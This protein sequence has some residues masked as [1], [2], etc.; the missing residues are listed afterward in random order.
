M[1]PLG[2]AQWWH[3]F[4]FLGLSFDDDDDGIPAAPTPASSGRNVHFKSPKNLATI[5]GFGRDRVV[6]VPVDGQRNFVGVLRESGSAGMVALE[7]DGRVLSFDV[8]NL[9]KARLV[10]AI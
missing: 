7:V 9:E 3:P 8:G 4:P 2:Q 10:P 6:R 1:L 5:S